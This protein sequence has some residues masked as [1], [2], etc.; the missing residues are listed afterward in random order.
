MTR[1][2]TKG[3]SRISNGKIRSMIMFSHRSI[4][5]R[6]NRMKSKCKSISSRGRS[7]NMS[8]SRGICRNNIGGRNLIRS[9]SMAGLG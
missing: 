5:R 9:R 4:S 2:C 7:E 1:K 6:R 8:K 3:N